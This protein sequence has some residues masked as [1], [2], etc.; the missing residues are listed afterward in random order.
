MADGTNARQITKAKL[1]SVLATF[2]RHVPHVAIM[3]QNMLCVPDPVSPMPEIVDGRIRAESPAGEHLFWVPTKGQT[4]CEVL[5][6][7]C[8]RMGR[9]VRVDVVQPKC[10]TRLRSRNTMAF[11]AAFHAP[12]CLVVLLAPR[13]CCDNSAELAIHHRHVDCLKV[14]VGALRTDAEHAVYM[15]T[16]VIVFENGYVMYPTAGTH[17]PFQAIYL[18]VRS[19]RK[20]FT[21]P[22]IVTMEVYMDEMAEKRRMP[23]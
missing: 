6:A 14:L 12:L 2:N 18:L 23:T 9:T 10:V 21:D 8:A 13:Y 20:Y 5:A 16:P 15:R 17:T 19:T 3:L 11:S 22:M 7:I 4:A 1:V